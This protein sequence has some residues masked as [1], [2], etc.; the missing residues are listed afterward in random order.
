MLYLTANLDINLLNNLLINYLNKSMQNVRGKDIAREE[1][2][3]HLVRGVIGNG[4][5]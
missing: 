2:D 4:E 1:T 5:G 3:H